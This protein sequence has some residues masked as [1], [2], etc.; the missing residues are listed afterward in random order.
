MS[1]SC[2]VIR[3]EI[4]DTVGHMAISSESGTPK[5]VLCTVESSHVCLSLSGRDYLPR[6]SLSCSSPRAWVS[7]TM[8]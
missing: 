1:E 2:S 8:V 6:A 3:M 5:V 7:N 4:S